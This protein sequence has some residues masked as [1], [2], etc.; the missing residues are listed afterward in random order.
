MTEA[1]YQELVNAARFAECPQCGGSFERRN[2]PRD[3]E[4]RELCGAMCART[5][6]RAHAPLAINTARRGDNYGG[7]DI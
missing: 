2:G 6:E 1:K 3:E 7:I 4:G 5:Y